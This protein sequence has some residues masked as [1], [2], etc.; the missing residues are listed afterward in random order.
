MNESNELEERSLYGGAMAI[1][2]NKEYVDLSSIREVPDHQE[3]FQTITKDQLPA[4]ANARGCCFIVELLDLETTASD[5]ACS[6]YY[7]T[8][9]SDA[10]GALN[11]NIT[12]KHDS[13]SNNDAQSILSNMN[14]ENVFIGICNGWQDVS[15]DNMNATQRIWIDLCVIR[16]KDVA[17][18]VLITLTVPVS[19]HD[20]SHNSSFIHILSSLRINDWSLFA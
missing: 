17:T 2:L 5:E 7:F 10:N 18:D 9:L 16:L 8:D 11:K 6:A 3:V 15:L 13:L 12:N 20:T 19:N 1:S 14:A 4:H